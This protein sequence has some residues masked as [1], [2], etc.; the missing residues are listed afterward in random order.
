MDATQR[1]G[2]NKC[3]DVW[4]TKQKKTLT[5]KGLKN[6][7]S[8]LLSRPSTGLSFV[9]A[10]VFSVLFL[11]LLSL[12]LSL[13]SAHTH[14]NNYFVYIRLRCCHLSKFSVMV[15]SVANIALFMKDFAFLLE[16]LCFVHAALKISDFESLN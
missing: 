9:T 7:T 10:P 6:T 5:H 11:R 16:M 1:V 8:C 3:L 13:S 4:Y 2:D 15:T 12:S 14:M